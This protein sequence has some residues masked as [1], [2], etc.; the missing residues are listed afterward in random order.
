VSYAITHFALGASC[1]LLAL[2]AFVP[3]AERRRPRFRPLPLAVVG[4]VWAMAP[5]VHHLHEP[6]WD[7]TK[8]VIH[9]T[10]LA[11]VFWFHGVLD[12][13]DSPHSYVTAAASLAVLLT[14]SVLVEV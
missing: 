6:L 9:D 8:P 1:T 5:D 14:L 11:N 7:V 2:L 10:G 13:F 3:R 12:T 4:G